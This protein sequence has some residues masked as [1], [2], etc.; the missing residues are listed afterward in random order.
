MR[1]KQ[2]SVRSAALALMVLSVIWGYNWVVMKE[3]MKYSGPFDFA[4]LRTV[5]GALSLFIVLLWLKKPLRPVELK[6]TLLLGLL[7]TTGFT[8]LSQ[9]ALVAG[10]AGKTAVL[11]YTMPFWVLLMAWPLLNEHIRGL[12]WLAAGLAFAGLIFIFDPW[13][14]HGTFASSVLAILSGV[15]WAASAIVAKKLR[16]RAQVDLLSLTAWQML[17]GA[18]ALMII[19][20]LVPSRPIE[21]TVNFIGTLIY[22]TILGTALGWLLWLYILHSLPAGVASLGS[23]GIPVVGVLAAWLQLEELPTGAEITGMLMIVAALA[24]LSLLAIREHRRDY[25][26]EMGQE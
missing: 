11:A 25:D 14:A 4:A 17:L 3:A 13:Q 1:A 20:L 26:E 12:Q 7:Q 6:F 19:A 18:I 23:M 10:G 9:W 16:S 22:V 21:F 8:A 24:L 2:R 15:S 5:F